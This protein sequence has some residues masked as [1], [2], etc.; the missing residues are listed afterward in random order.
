MDDYKRM[1]AV[2]LILILI[3]ANLAVAIVTEFDFDDEKSNSDMEYYRG[4]KESVSSSVSG[5]DSDN[6]KNSPEDNPAVTGSSDSNEKD[7]EVH[8]AA[9]KTDGEVTEK[10]Q[11]VQTVSLKRKPVIPAA[12]FSGTSEAQ[13]MIKIEGELEGLVSK[14]V[15]HVT[16]PVGSDGIKYI[17]DPQGLI[18]KTNTAAYP[19]SVFDPDSNVYFSNGTVVNSDGISV[20]SYSG[21][22]DPFTVVNKSS[23]AVDVVARITAM[24]E[25]GPETKV[26]LAQNNV[27]EGISR[28][29]IYLSAVRSDDFSEKIVIS[30]R[31][32]AITASVRGC[33]GAYCYRYAGPNS[34]RYELMTDEELEEFRAGPSGR[35]TDTAF[36]EFSLA[37]RG[38]CNADGDWDPDEDYNFPSVSIV[39]NVGL[40]ASAGPY[41]LED[42][43]S[44]ARDEENILNYSMGL[45]DASADMI[46]SAMY[47]TPENVERELRWNDYYLQFSEHEI[48]LT[49]EFSGYARERNGGILRFRF[50]DRNK[51]T[52]EVKLDMSAAPSLSDSGCTIESGSSSQIKIGFD[53]G[54][55]DKAATGISKITFGN[56]D[57]TGRVYSSVNENE[58]T[59]SSIAVRM[60]QEKNGGTL[61][62]KFD[63]SARTSCSYKIK[64]GR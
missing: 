55:G 29:S 5:P 48:R 23:C 10:K 6:S 37:V 31:E 40:A 50:D 33:P 32:Q 12:D 11:N 42:E 52:F 54:S 9:E 2:L 3:I 61:R 7:S 53:L 57:F 60:I 56:E 4:I 63:D 8:E 38:E 58:I 39:W 30:Q 51:S 59:L 22:S 24:Y 49:P 13:S 21:T 64:T 43:V 62:V 25:K 36:K 17:A 18:C 35:T 28:P 14:N 41:I 46:R 26:S 27:W 16:L 1:A 45:L 44:V 34:Y 47:I 19:D 20:T 15:F